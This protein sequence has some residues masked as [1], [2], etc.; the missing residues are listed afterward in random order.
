MMVRQ[1]TGGIDM[2][3]NEM[4][5]APAATNHYSLPGAGRYERIL[6]VSQIYKLEARQSGGKL[7]CIEV[8]VPPGQGIPRHRHRDEDESFYIIAGRVLIEGDDLGGAPVCL[9]AGSFFHGPR[10]WIHGF[11][12]EGPEAAK[13]LVFI[14]PG[15]GSEAMFAKLADLTLQQGSAIDPARVAAIAGEH[16]I[17]VIGPGQ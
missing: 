7:V 4:T 3:M 14:S 15:A 12:C 2:S 10:G 11:R 17:T 5:D 1:A 16:G 6:G 8:T 9:E 13:L